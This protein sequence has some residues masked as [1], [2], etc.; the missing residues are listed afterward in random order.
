MSHFGQSPLPWSPPDHWHYKWL[1]LNWQFK[2]CCTLSQLTQSWLVAASF[3]GKHIIC[4][5]TF[6]WAVECWMLAGMF[7]AGHQVSCWMW[8]VVLM[9]RYWRGLA[10]VGTTLDTNCRVFSLS[11]TGP[12]ELKTLRLSARCI[13]LRLFT[14]PVSQA[15]GYKGDIHG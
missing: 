15:W 2:S 7:I 6:G 13:S 4:C 14:S 1:W 5:L 3:A 12:T 9:T 8:A 10:T 11:F